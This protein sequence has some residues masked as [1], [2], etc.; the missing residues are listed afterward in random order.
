MHA[1]ISPDGPWVAYSSTI[2]GRRDVHV[3]EPAPGSSR[4]VVVVNWLTEF[5]GRV[6]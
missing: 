1:R 3:L 2:S 6:K 4:M 5:L